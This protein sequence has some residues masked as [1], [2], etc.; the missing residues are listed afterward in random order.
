MGPSS[1]NPFGNDCDMSEGERMALDCMDAYEEERGLDPY[2]REEFERLDHIDGPKGVWNA[3]SGPI[4]MT[5]MTDSHIENALKWLARY[6]L[7]DTEKGDE[8]RA[9]QARRAKAA[10]WPPPPGSLRSRG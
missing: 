1:Y 6:D 7:V 9:E 5:E 4:A 3:T 10:P 8:L 2:D